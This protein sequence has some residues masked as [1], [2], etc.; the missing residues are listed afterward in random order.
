MVDLETRVDATVQTHADRQQSDGQRSV[1]AR[2]R[3]DDQADSRTVL[4]HTV[5]DLTRSGVRESIRV[6]HVVGDERNANREEPHRNVGQSR[7]ETVL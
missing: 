3:G 1:T 4:A 7:E 2:V 5:D 6:D